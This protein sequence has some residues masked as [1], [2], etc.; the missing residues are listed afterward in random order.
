MPTK[1]EINKMVKQYEAG[2][3]LREIGD[4]LGISYVR[5]R[6]YLLEA[7]VEMRSRGRVPQLDPQMVSDKLATGISKAE[8]ARSLKVHVSAVSYAMRRHASAA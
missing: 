6:H 1:A 7:G 2:K 3:S 8:L 5:V 4:K